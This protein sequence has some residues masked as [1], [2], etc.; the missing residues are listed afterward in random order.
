MCHQNTTATAAE[1]NPFAK[2]FEAH[3]NYLTPKKKQQKN[4]KEKTRV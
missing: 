2:A 3:I 4:K 1:E